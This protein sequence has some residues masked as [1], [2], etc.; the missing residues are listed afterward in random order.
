MFVFC[1]LRTCS[2]AGAR[3][4]Q[5]FDGQVAD[6]MMVLVGRLQQTGGFGFSVS[7]QTV[8][9]ASVQTVVPAAVQ[10]VTPASVQT[11]VPASVQTVFQQ[12]WCRCKNIEGSS[13]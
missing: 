11:V 5:I 7:F 9:P 10:T 3:L 6:V 2:T 12:L 4:G 1:R 8:I 13:F